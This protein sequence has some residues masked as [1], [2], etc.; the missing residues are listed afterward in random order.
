M[1]SQPL[2]S[3]SCRRIARG[4][5]QDVVR[6]WGHGG[7][8]H[9]FE[10]AGGR[11]GSWDLKTLQWWW[12]DDPDVLRERQEAWGERDATFRAI[13]EALAQAGEEMGWWT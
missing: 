3:R 7:Y 11:R 10:A 1:G 6:A 4:T 8:V 2:S 9:T 5:G 13:R 12:D